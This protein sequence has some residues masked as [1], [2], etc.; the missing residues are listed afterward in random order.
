[1]MHGLHWYDYGAR[2]YDPCI[3]RFTTMDPMCEKY[4]NLSPYAYCGNN[5]VNYIDLHG[6]SIIIDKY[7]EELQIR[8]KNNNVY[9]KDGDSYKEIGVIGE[10][11]NIDDI[12]KNIFD[13]NSKIA[14]NIKNPKTFYD[15]VKTSG[16][17]DL[18]N[19]PNSIWQ[20]GRTH[21]TNFVFNKK[22]LSAEDVGNLNFGV[23][24]KAYG[25]PEKTALIGAG[26]Y[27]IYSGTSSS[28]WIKIQ[29][30]PTSLYTPSGDIIVINSFR[31]QSPYGDDPVDQY[32]I[33][34]GYN[35]K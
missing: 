34:R 18:K 23:V 22:K 16:N 35:Y 1:M 27:Q 13:R 17:W 8:G 28:E 9:I 10:E 29:I 6:D 15:L 2:H 4:Y 30:T 21:N 25:V 31:L 33:K 20:Y 3:M 24:A 14:K 19:L 5:P 26:L 12:T 32:W 7:G 11:I